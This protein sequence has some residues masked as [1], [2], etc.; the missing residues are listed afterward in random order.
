VTADAE[1]ARHLPGRSTGREQQDDTATK[2]QLLRSGS[3]P[4][5]T[6]EFHAID[7]LD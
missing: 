4:Q 5:P 7:W 1:L 2:S 6:F 3:C